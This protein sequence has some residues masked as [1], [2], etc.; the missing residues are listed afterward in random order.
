M[1][2]KINNLKR[3]TKEERTGRRAKSHVKLETEAELS[4]LPSSLEDEGERL[5]T[6]SEKF[7]PSSHV[8][9]LSGPAQPPS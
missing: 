1:Q 2:R 3:E 8:T 4:F 5:E 7:Q 9:G 6:G